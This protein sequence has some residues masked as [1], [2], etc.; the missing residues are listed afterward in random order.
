MILTTEQQETIKAVQNMDS[1][2]AAKAL[3]VLLSKDIDIV[4]IIMTNMKGDKKSEILDNM[5]SESA[6]TVIKLI[7]PWEGGN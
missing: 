7:L 6:A 4:K 1:E 5:N 2:Q 3:E